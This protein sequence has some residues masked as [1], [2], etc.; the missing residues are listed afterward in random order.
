MKNI[1]Y[2]IMLVLSFAS[3]FGQQPVFEWAKQTG[4]TGTDNGTKITLDAS[5]NVYT[6][7]SFQGTVDFDPGTGISTLISNGSSDIFITKFDA[8]GNFIWARQM[9]GILSD[10]GV[11]I[12]VHTTGEIYVTGVFQDAV[13]F[14]P[15]I[16]ITTLVSA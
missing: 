8:S 13:D 5:G 11:S 9:G 16:G 14:N 3:S 1:F 4:G 15:N 10:A 12:D 2:T 6:T 7:G